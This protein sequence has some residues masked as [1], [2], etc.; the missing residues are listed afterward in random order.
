MI[1]QKEDN[2][3]VK[4]GVKERGRARRIKAVLFGIVVYKVLLLKI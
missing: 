3:M 2:K 4:F 1:K